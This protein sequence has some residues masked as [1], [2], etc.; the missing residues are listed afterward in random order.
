MA[1]NGVA[2]DGLLL[3]FHLNRQRLIELKHSCF[4][5]DGVEFFGSQAVV[6]IVGNVDL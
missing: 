1:G 2:A 4:I 3:V 5:E 6:N